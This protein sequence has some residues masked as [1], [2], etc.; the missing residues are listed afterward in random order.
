MLGCRGFFMTQFYCYL[1]IEDPEGVK[2]E[3]GFA[4]FLAGKMWFHA[5]GLGF[6][7]KK[8]IENGNRTKIWARQAQWQ[9]DLCSGT[10]GFSKNLGWEM[11]IGSPL[12][13]PLYRYQKNH[14]WT[15]TGGG[16]GAGSVSLTFGQSSLP[17]T[18]EWNVTLVYQRTLKCFQ[19]QV[20]LNFWEI[21]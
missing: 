11:G 16:G 1:Y 20:F 8:P 4:H 12:Q 7:N 10:M 3:L 9:R 15:R 6:I 17:H 13:D 19:V 2:W 18:L 5:L 14:I 21:S